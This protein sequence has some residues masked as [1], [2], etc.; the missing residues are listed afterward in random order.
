MP[1]P[2]PS[3]DQNLTA[4][5]WMEF[6]TWFLAVLDLKFSQQEAVLR[7]LM[8]S[9]P[10]SEM[11]QMPARINVDEIDTEGYRDLGNHGSDHGENGDHG[12]HSVAK[13]RMTTL[14]VTIMYEKMQPEPPVKQFVK[15]R[16]DLYMGGVVFINMIFMVVMT[17]WTGSRAEASLGLIPEAWP[18]FTDTFFE[19]AEYCFFALYLADVVFRIAVLRSEWYFDMQEGYMYLNMFDACLVCISTFELILLPAIFSAGGNPEIETNTIRVLKLIRIVRTLRIFK[20]VS[21]FRQLRL[22]VSTCIASIGA[23][24]WSMILLLLLNIAFALMMAQALQT[25]ILDE[26]ADLDTRILMNQYYGSFTQA[27]YTIFEVTHSGSWPSRVRPVLDSVD[28]W[29]AALFLPYIALVVFAVIRVVTALFIKETLA[30]AANDAELVIEETRRNAL[31][32]QEKLEELFQ[33][34]DDDGDGH[35]TPS[36]FVE[37]MSLPSVQQY[38]KFL[39]VSVRDVRPL[40]DILSEGDGLITIAEFCKGLMQLKGQARALDIVILQHEN[41]KLMRQCH[42]IHRAIC[43]AA[44]PYS[45]RGGF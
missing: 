12:D 11:S 44:Q 14:G 15:T 37:A 38:M 19:V 17:Q 5:E 16:L 28:P 8:E 40:F 2:S 43:E 10:Q 13:K 25:F 31:E 29:Y 26:R 22:L 9:L 35:L 41:S 27:F 32:Y 4:A 45:P 42:E 21:V 20:T 33:I 3:A 24:F 30:S 18:F 7:G 34:V 36:E 23:L 39:D 1:T 6:Q